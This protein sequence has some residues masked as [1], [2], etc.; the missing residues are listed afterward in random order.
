MGVYKN[1]G[2][3]FRAVAIDK[4]EQVA[5]EMMTATL[6]ANKDINLMNEI[7]LSLFR[8]FLISA[9][10]YAKEE[11]GW[12]KRRKDSWTSIVNPDYIFHDGAMQD[13]RHWDCDIIGQI[14]YV[15]RR[16][17]SLAKIQKVQLRIFMRS[18]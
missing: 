4:E 10:V 9:T 13:V 14:I 16:K 8:E 3:D 15:L 18:S 11:W 1:Q 12:K 5:A 2:T 7:E 17:D 6:Q